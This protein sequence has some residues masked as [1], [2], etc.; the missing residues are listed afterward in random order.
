MKNESTRITTYLWEGLNKYG[1]RVKGE[2]VSISATSVQIELKKQGIVVI[3]I[4]KKLKLLFTFKQGIKSQDITLMSRHLATMSA[5]GISLVQALDISAKSQIK[6]N[7][8]SLINEIKNDVASG[9]MFSESLKKHPKYFGELFC[10]LVQTGEQSGTLAMVLEQLANHLEKSE[11]LKKKIMKAMYYPATVL[12]TACCVA[13]LL[14]LFVVPQFEKLFKSFGAQLPLFTRMVI[15]LSLMLQSYWHIFGLLT[16]TIICLLMYG[17]KNSKKFTL[18]FDRML[19]TIPIFGNFLKKAI[20]ARVTRTLATTL[21]AGIPMLRALNSAATVTGN[22][23]YTHAILQVSDE[24]ATGQQIHAAMNFSQVFPN[25][26]V[27]M[28][29]IG[30]ESGAVDKML[31]KIATF[32]EEELENMTSGLTALMEPMIIIILSVVIGGFILAMYLPIFR[33]GSII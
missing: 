13:I 5:A 26:L 27:Q 4:R 29:A 3:K 6:T 2:L 14:M 28:V 9:K 21:S 7:T 19:L 15:D 22:S 20:I 25:M 31:D 24:V 1:L 17:R 33:L 32:Y 11:L 23:V 8:Q 30:E 10:S 16:V 18:Y 12:C